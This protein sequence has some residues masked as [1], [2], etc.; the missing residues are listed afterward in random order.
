[1]TRN[2]SAVKDVLCGRRKRTHC[3]DVQ[4]EIV[5]GAIRFATARGLLHVGHDGRQKL[6]QV[7]EEGKS[8]EETSMG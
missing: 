6:E 2:I 8:P 5:L 7:S 1:M 4:R 3:S